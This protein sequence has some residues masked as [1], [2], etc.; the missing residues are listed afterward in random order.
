MTLE[1]LLNSYSMAQMALISHVAFLKFK[2]DEDRT[3]KDEDAPGKEVGRGSRAPMKGKCLNEGDVDNAKA[4][5]L[6]SSGLLH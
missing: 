3:K 1:T 6:I 4:F 5:W 2:D